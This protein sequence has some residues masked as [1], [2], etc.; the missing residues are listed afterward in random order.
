MQKSLTWILL[1]AAGAVFALILVLERTVP[2]TAEREQPGPLI[3]AGQ[4]SEASSIR[5]AFGAD[6]VVLAER[7]NEGWMLRNPNYPAQEPAIENFLT[8]LASVRR[9]DRLPAHEV[10]LQGAASFGLEPVRATVE[11]ISGTNRT[12]FQ[13]GGRAPLTNN[14]YLRLQPSGDVIV[15]SA[16]AGELL[17]ASPLAWRDPRVINLASL[18]FDQL[19]IRN[20]PRTLELARD[21]T[22]RLWRITR[23]V[24]TRANQERLIGLIDL[25][26][27]ATVRQYVADSPADLER[28][29]LQAPALEFSVLQGTNRLYAIEFG[30]AVTNQPELVYARLLGA[31]NVV[32]V[33]RELASFLS[34]PSK[35]FQDA[36]LFSFR[37]AAIDRIL[38][39]STE[40]FELQRQPN[41]AWTGKHGNREIPIDRFL[42]QRFLTNVLA[43]EIIDIAKEVP[44]EIDLQN[45]GLL[46]PRAS[47]AFFERLTNSNA[48]LTNIQFTEVSFGTNIADRV[49]ARRSDEIPVYYTPLAQL[50]VLPDEAFEL[51][52]R[53]LWP[54]SPDAIRRV[55]FS[56]RA[57][58]NSLARGENGVWSNDAILNEAI[59]E[60]VHRLATVEAVEWT[61]KGEQRKPALGIRDDPLTLTVE[62]GSEVYRVQFGFETIQR[63]VY[64]AVDLPG[65]AEPV[66]F[67]FPGLLFHSLAQL[68]PIPR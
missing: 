68:L 50:V 17:P 25:L 20:G 57:G 34:Q 45:F 1:A 60:A 40:K 53:R 13:V 12:V 29:G 37:P 9:L 64:A 22:N 48:V 26:R 55:S 39:E 2:G 7:T 51:R 19:R 58:T 21:P 38:V 54:V 47:L 3:P 36:R 41:G 44:T 61:S 32:A 31:S 30:S 16:A 67:Q 66:L 56:N 11:V 10:A 23:P 49:L 15:A 35:T 46:R 8:N 63:Q 18:S 62:T 6:G 14:F 42:L 65:E 27:N 43:L 52:D 59:G 24:P 33:P 4:L 5:I 28:F